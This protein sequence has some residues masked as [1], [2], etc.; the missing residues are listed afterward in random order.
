MITG[1]KS[2]QNYV[3]FMCD[4]KGKYGDVNALVALR[5]TADHSL[6][7][8]CLEILGIS[9]SPLAGN[10]FYFRISII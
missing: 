7:S 3:R 1:M 8:S 6:C 9:E 10:V 5:Q 2:L 4:W